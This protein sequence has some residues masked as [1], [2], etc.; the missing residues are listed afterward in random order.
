MLGERSHT[1][2]AGG[3]LLDEVLSLCFDTSASAN[4]SVC[5]RNSWMGM[6]HEEREKALLLLWIDVV[7]RVHSCTGKSS[8]FMLKVAVSVYLTKIL[9]PS[10]TRAIFGKAQLAPRYNYR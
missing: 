9:R 3:V 1:D 2:V 6:H 5:R 7:I 10:L 8:H 4:P